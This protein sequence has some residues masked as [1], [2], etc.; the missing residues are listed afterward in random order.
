MKKCSLWAG[1][2]SLRSRDFGQLCYG[3]GLLPRNSL[4]M[5]IIGFFSVEGTQVLL[6]FVDSLSA[7]TAPH[8]MH[9][10]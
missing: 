5:I 4:P 8:L 2:V 9:P 1:Y 10:A 6:I 7:Q 3:H